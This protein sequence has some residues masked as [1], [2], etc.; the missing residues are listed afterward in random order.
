V[1]H[2]L[3]KA[4]VPV[5]RIVAIPIGEDEPH[6]DL[7][8]A[9]DYGLDGHFADFGQQ[10][11]NQSVYMVVFWPEEKMSSNTGGVKPQAALLSG[12]TLESK[13]KKFMQ[14]LS[15]EKDLKTIKN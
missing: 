14:Y 9:I 11:L 2:G 1:W 13:Q 4:G 8:L 7:Q 6:I 12:A 10:P 5:D 3:A 15:G